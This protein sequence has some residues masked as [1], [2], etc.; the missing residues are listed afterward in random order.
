MSWNHRNGRLF[1][2]LFLVFFASFWT[3]CSDSSS[4]PSE[5]DGDADSDL[6]APGEEEEEADGDGEGEAEDEPAYPD[7]TFIFENRQPTYPVLDEPYEQEFTEYFRTPAQLPDLDVRALAVIEGTVFAGAPTGL[8]AKAPGDVAFVLLEASPAGEGEGGDADDEAA[9]EETPPY[10]GVVD[11]ARN[12]FDGKIPVAFPDRVVLVS[13]TDQQSQSLPFDG[14]EITAVAAGGGRLVIG[15]VDGIW[16]WQGDEWQPLVLM[17]SLL[18]AR[19]IVVHSD[20]KVYAAVG[21]RGVFIAGAEGMEGNLTAENG[22][23]PDDD[24]RAVASCGDRLVVATQSG[25]AVHQGAEKILKTAGV[26]ALPTDDNLVVDCNATHILIGHAIGATLVPHDFSKVDHYSS[27]RWVL[28]NRVPAVAL[29]DGPVV[30]AGGAQGVTRIYRQTRT[31]VDKE[32]VFDALAPNYWRMDG[33]F[34][35]E[36]WVATPWDDPSTMSKSDNDNDGL[37]TQMMIGGW[38][39]AYAL[40]GDEKYYQYARKG[41]DNMFKLIDIPAVS[42]QEK[43]MQRGFVSRSIVRDDEGPVYESK[44]TQGNWHQV[45]VDERSYYWKSDTSSDETTGHFFGYPV[46][47]DL[48]AK[49]GE[50]RAAVAE[51]AAALARYIV[52][53][54]FLLIDLDGQRTS[55]GVW[56]PESLAIAVDGLTECLKNGYD[57]AACGEAYYGGGW[58]NSLE[59]LGHLLAA[60]HMTGDTY[61]YDAYDM[62]IEE[63]RYDEV[64]MPNEDTLTITGTAIANHSDH[65]LAMLAYTTLIRYEPNEA[66]RQQWVKGLEFLYDWERIEHNPWWTA[67]MALSGG[68]LTQE[69]VNNSRN[70]LRELPDDVREWLVDNRYRKD[71]GKILPARNNSEQGEFRLP[72]DEIKTMWWNGTPRDI[73]GGGAGNSWKAP[74]F[75]LLPYYMNLYSGLIVPEGK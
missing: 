14:P 1:C 59:I 71:F 4:E 67:V 12:F 33:F 13:L 37:W 30:W 54:G 50:E 72:Y 9:E 23:L 16:E 29:A 3:A 28:D 36:G 62:L 18:F 66:R 10:A 38:C 22:D 35:A 49:T 17:D 70:T 6:D 26:G 44:A 65:E 73:S 41:M 31:L 68:A 11:I 75:F 60:W 32:P 19:D 5:T 51:H 61:F 39:F 48:C 40:T 20:G 15:A 2:L 25:I 58:L 53:G 69:D 52:E 63:Y 27:M 42:F 55:F 24:A 34:A 7:H 21:G 8:Y 47:Y 57:I 43:G 45:T 56:N 64:A 74:T 46:F